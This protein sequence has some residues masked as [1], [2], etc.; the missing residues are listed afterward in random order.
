M[1]GPPKARHVDRPV[2]AALEDLVPPDHFYRHLE[3][4]LDL[5]FVRDLVRDRYAP[6]GRPSLDPVVFFRLQLVMFFEGIRSE[7]KLLETASLHPAH[8]WYLGYA[9]DE[10]LPDASTLTRLRQRLGV[11]VFR[12]FFEHVVELCQ[13]AGLV[14]GRELFFDATRVKANAAAASVVP[15]LGRVVDDHIEE[16]FPGAEPAEPAAPAEPIAATPGVVPLP[17][18]AGVEAAGRWDVLAQGRLD[19]QRAPTGSHRRL[20]AERVCRTDPDAALMRAG[21]GRATVGYQVHYVVDGGRA[22]IILHDPPRAGDP[23]RRPRASADARPPAAR[24]LPVARPAPAGGGRL[25]VRHRREHRGAGGRGH[26]GLLPPG[27]LGGPHAVLRPSSLRLRPRPGRVPLPPGAGPAPPPRLLPHRGLD[28]PRRPSRL[29]CLPR[30][31]GLHRQPPRAV[32]HPL[33]LRRVPGPGAGLPRDRRLQEGDAQAGSSG[34]SRC[35]GRP[36]SGTACVLFGNISTPGGS[37]SS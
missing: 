33:V 16:L 29:R 24:V 2:L 1:L 30:A 34:S 10:A 15:R 3:A 26:P 18:V 5:S 8:R 17:G 27:R 36:N 32:A 11:S 12:R 14:R 13:A 19:P 23:R 21:G 22:R 7:R 28:L 25:Q 20:S 31:G 9:L 6:G 35:S 4:A 37:A